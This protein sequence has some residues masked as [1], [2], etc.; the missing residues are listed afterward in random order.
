MGNPP[1]STRVNGPLKGRNARP[2]VHRH[3]LAPVFDAACLMSVCKQGWKIVNGLMTAPVLLLWELFGAGFP[4][5]LPL[6]TFLDC[7]DETK[8]T[9]EMNRRGKCRFVLPMLDLLE[10]SFYALTKNLKLQ[11]RTQYAKPYY[12]SKIFCCLRYSVNKTIIYPSSIF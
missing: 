4:S 6:S 2:R 11:R 9:R 7:D 12:I 8:S 10:F 5:T 3:V 1:L